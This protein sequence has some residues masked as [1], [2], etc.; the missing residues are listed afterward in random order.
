M[1]GIVKNTDCRRERFFRITGG[2][3]LIV[4]A[5]RH[6]NSVIGCYGIVT[7]FLCSN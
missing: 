6:I 7:M 1:E 2:R 5:Q 4:P 3:I